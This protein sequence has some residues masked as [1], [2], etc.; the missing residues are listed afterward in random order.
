MFL[1]TFSFSC[2]GFDV[3]IS[4]TCIVWIIHAIGNERW[5]GV[6]GASLLRALCS[7]LF[8]SAK[9]VI[10]TTVLS[11]NCSRSY[12]VH[13][14]PWLYGFGFHFGDVLWHRDRRAQCQTL[15]MKTYKA[16]PICD[17]GTVDQW[18]RILWRGEMTTSGFQMCWSLLDCFAFMPPSEWS[19]INHLNWV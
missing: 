8:L 2:S 19:Q 10:L 6:S 1:C 5:P 4:F 11:T 9:P 7:F 13:T 3:L 17:Y 15:K 12:L 18:K 16:L 14:V